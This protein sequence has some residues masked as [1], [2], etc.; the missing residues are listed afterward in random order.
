M[1]PTLLD[2]PDLMIRQIA[3][4][5]SCCINGNPQGSAILFI[6]VS[7]EFSDPDDLA[8]TK[9]IPEPRDG[10]SGDHLR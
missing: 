2:S 4:S 10:R 8:V 5:P 1:V 3:E 7:S 6:E 9:L